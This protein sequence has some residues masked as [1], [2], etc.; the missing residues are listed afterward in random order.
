MFYLEE[1][2]LSCENSP[3]KGT[4]EGHELKFKLNVVEERSPTVRNLADDSAKA[5]AKRND[6]KIRKKDWL[7]LND[8]EIREKNRFSFSR[9]AD[10]APSVA[11]NARTFPSSSSFS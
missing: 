11:Y 5:P 3:I 9:W 7:G 4:T 2:E 8:R 6:R 1:G 10:H